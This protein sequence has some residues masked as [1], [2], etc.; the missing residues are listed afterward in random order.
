[1][2]KNYVF[3]SKNLVIL[4]LILNIFSSI[5]VAASDEVTNEFDKLP[6]KNLIVN[7]ETFDEF[8]TNKDYISYTTLSATDYQIPIKISKNGQYNNI[9]VKSITGA[10]GN[11]EDRGV[12]AYNASNSNLNGIYVAFFLN[13]RVDWCGGAVERIV[14]K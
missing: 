5:N 8:T 11:D 4:L 1:M 10:S 3:C 13:G 14:G 6:K 12:Q 2:K 7:N 9:S